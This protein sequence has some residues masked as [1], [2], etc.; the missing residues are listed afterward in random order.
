MI[1]AFAVKL[2]GPIRPK[3]VTERSNKFLWG[4]TQAKEAEENGSHIT[5]HVSSELRPLTF[6]SLL[7]TCRLFYLDLTRC[8]VFYRVGRLY[9]PI[10]QVDLKALGDPD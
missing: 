3:Q 1:W 9:L 2:D 4:A 5:Y 10:V 8:P 7:L 6:T